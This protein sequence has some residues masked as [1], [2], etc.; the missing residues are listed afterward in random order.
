MQRLIRLVCAFACA[1]LVPVTASAQL[2]QASIAGVVRDPSGAVLPGVTVEAASPAL[3]E[4]VRTVVTDGN[5]QYRLVDLRPGTYTVTFS[6]QGFSTVRREGIELIGTFNATINADMKVGALEETVTVTGESPIVDVQ[7]STA[8]RV[9][10]QEV[11]EAIPAGR[12]HINQMV[13][14]PGLQAS[15][16]GRGALQD[17]GGTNNLQNTTFVIHG[18]RQGDTRLQL[19]GVRLG[20]VLSEGQ[21][22]NYVPDTGSTQEVTIDYA[23]VSAEQ[24]YGGLR[25]NIVPKEGGNDIRGSIFATG[26]NS[27]W[28]G[29][30]MTDDLRARGLPDPNRMKQAYDINP[31]IGGPILHDKM[32]FYGSARFQDNQ[33]YVAGL[34]INRNAGD[35]TKWLPDPDRGQQ[36]VFKVRQNGWNGRLTYQAAQ[37]HKFSFY[38]DDQTRDWDDSRA[39]I[40]PESTVAYRFPTLRLAQG[41]YTATLS[42]KLLVEAR[43]ANRGEAFGNQYPEEGSP[44]RKLI[45]VIEQTTSLQYRGKGGDGGSSG[46]FGFSSQNINTA[47]ASMSYV[48][49]SHSLKGGFSDTWARTRSESRTND[50]ALL[51]RFTNGIPTQLTQYAP[52]A[53]GTGT[54]VK[55]EI[56]AFVQDRWTINRLTLNMGLRYDQYIGGYPD[57]NIGP[58]F[59]LPNRSFNFSELTTNNLKDFTPRVQAGYD[60]FGNGKTALKASIGKYVLATTTSGNPAPTGAATQTTRAWNDNMYPAG[61]PRNGNFS[62][63]CDLFNGA[64]NGECGPWNPAN[65]GTLGAV[66]VVNP[67]TRFGWGNRPWNAEFSTSIT[68]ELMPRIGVDFG[69]FRRWYGNFLAI[70]NRTNAASDFSAYQITAPSDPRLPGGG[71]YVVPGLYN[72]NPDKFGQNSQYTTFA[73]DFGKMTETW[74]GVDLSVNARLQNGIMLQGGFNTGRTITDNCEVAAKAGSTTS[75]LVFTDNPT[76]LYCHNVGNFLNQVKML[77][78]YMLPRI[79]VNVAAT[80]QSSP[81]PNILAQYI[82]TNAV[83]QPSLGRALSGGAANVTVNLVEPNTLYGDRVNQLDFRLGKT[84]R[85]GARRAMVN[86]DIYNAL[87]SSVVLQMNNNYASWQIPQRI[88][89]ARLFKFSGQFDF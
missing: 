20:N 73:S 60:L 74:N 16:P 2:T 6:L 66:T 53:S 28:Q 85:F 65:F 86:F 13:L 47:V 48:T 30:N 88:M 79:G 78:T 52:I 22:S 24:P 55:G 8:Q 76:Q 83:V 80:L 32:W 25:I 61:D 71:G 57:Q 3:I 50:S 31:S 7:A 33:N 87:N 64:T 40:S 19:D 77:G 46:L 45:P 4:K 49:G 21:F 51:Y 42:N 34:Y 11:I 72:L 43:F 70:D 63:D 1:V 39:T 14:I 84:F 10:T 59:F 5:G 69:F 67:D 54:L 36:G 56:G 81:G 17:V 58:A 29:S 18:S 12:S 38:Y 62:P 15:Q 75:T 82:A 89:D 9:F 27:A 68:H 35:A 23:A 37:K 41:G 26:V 44:Y